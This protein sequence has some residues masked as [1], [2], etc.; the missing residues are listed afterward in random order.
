[1][2]IRETFEFSSVPC[3]HESTPVNHFLYEECLTTL[4]RGQ[5]QLPSECDVLRHKAHRKGDIFV[6]RPGRGPSSPETVFLSR[7][8]A[9]GQTIFSIKQEKALWGIREWPAVTGR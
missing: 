6:T 2:K 3:H 8:A 5:V 1:M 4:R 7:L 9:E